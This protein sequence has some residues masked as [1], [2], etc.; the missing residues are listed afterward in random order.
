M[1]RRKF[2]KILGAT[3]ALLPVAYVTQRFR[4]NDDGRYGANPA[5]TEPAADPILTGN[6]TALL[7]IDPYNDFFSVDGAAW[8]LI[9]TVAE[10]NNLVGNV[11]DILTASRNK[12]LV[13]AYSPHHRYHKDSHLERKFLSPAQ[14]QQ[15]RSGAFPRDGFGGRYLTEPEP[16]DGEII[17]SEHSCSSGFAETD[18]DE[19]LKAEGV[20]HLIVVGCISNTCVEATVRSAIDLGYHVTVIADAIAG[21]SPR[22]HQL[23]TRHSFSWVAHRVSD[24]QTL[25][26]EMA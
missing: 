18:L 12:G 8:R 10:D 26:A 2:L 22:E 13:I 16:Q 21:F 7:L 23:A 3:T 15:R 11:S 24:T 25:L 20:T 9:S 14:Y 6:K 19:K 5:T 1:I 4:L 17:G